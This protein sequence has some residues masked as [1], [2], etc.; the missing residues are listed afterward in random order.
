MICGR[1]GLHKYRDEEFFC[2]VCW[3]GVVLGVTVSR[4][5]RAGDFGVESL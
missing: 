3:V 5:Y 2:I 1:V 4:D